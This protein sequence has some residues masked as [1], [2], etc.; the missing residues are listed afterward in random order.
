MEQSQAGKDK[1]PK[2]KAKQ[3]YTR[4]HRYT[5]TQRYT[6]PHTLWVNLIKTK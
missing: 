6:H 3:E 1:K 2:I 5:H 4:T